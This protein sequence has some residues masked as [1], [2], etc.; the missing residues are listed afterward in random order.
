MLLLKKIKDKCLYEKN[1]CSGILNLTKS[2]AN[3]T[4]R[5]IRVVF[6][7][8]SVNSWTRLQGVYE[9]MSHSDE[10]DVRILC[11]P[12]NKK[13]LK[14]SENEIYNFFKE[15]YDCINAIKNDGKLVNIKY[16]LWA[17]RKIDFLFYQNPYHDYLPQTYQAEYTSAYS[18]VCLVHYTLAFSDGMR[19]A[20]YDSFFFNHLSIFFSCTPQER[21]YCKARFNFLN[22]YGLQNCYFVGNPS[23]EA[24]N[25]ISKK[26]DF[27]VKESFKVIWTPRWTTD[28]YLG[29]STFHD[30]YKWMLEFSKQNKDIDFVFRPHPLLFRTFIDNGVL[31]RKEIE[32]FIG[33][34]GKTDNVLL[35]QNKEYLSTLS[36]ASIM[37]SDP[38]SIMVTFFSTGKPIVFLWQDGVHYT[39]YFN[40]MLKGCYIAHDT[41]EIGEYL[42]KLK[43]GDDPLK[44]TR[45][46]LITELYGDISKSVVDNIIGVLKK[47]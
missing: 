4:H 36:E 22:K 43:Q 35:D 8:Q 6:L 32:D 15:R 24:L 3:K 13:N 7:V 18:K 34:C 27:E 40:E 20:T 42:Y 47:S 33:T 11:V 29:G 25:K 14:S 31:T 19:V 21:D 39:K 38:S 5:P 44:E 28:K 17:D 37:I 1:R 41:D 16:D 12:S 10:F 30:Y 45:E 9:T 23:V 2:K 46:R 26:S